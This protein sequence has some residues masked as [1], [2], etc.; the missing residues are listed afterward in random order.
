FQHLLQ[1]ILAAYPALEA[2]DLPLGTPPKL[3]LGDLALP[4]FLAAKKLGCP[5]PKL[6]A[7]IATQVGFGKEVTAAIPAGP[8]LN[9]KVDRGALARAVADSI[10]QAGAAYGSD[11]SGAG[12]TVLLEHT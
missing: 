10:R 3:D 8:Y 2:A 9:L 12:R 11:Q 4:L 1:P 5:P 6:A 7:E